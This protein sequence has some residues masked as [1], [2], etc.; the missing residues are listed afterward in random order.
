MSEYSIR[1]NLSQDDDLSSATDI[2][3]AKTDPRG[4]DVHETVELMN[5]EIDTRNGGIKERRSAALNGQKQHKSMITMTDEHNNAFK[6]EHIIGEWRPGMNHKID[7]SG[8]FEFGGSCG[9]LALMTGFPLLMY[10]MWIGA[11]YYDGKL[12][13]PYEG[14][15]WALFG[16]HLLHLAYTEAFPHF[17][18]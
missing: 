4:R 3:T 11:T 12:P 7:D 6:R 15:S 13:L 14:Q 18:A 2:V 10:Y 17:R 1:N 16:K 8:H 9:S 5:A